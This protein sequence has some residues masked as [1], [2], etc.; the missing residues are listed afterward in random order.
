MKKL[1]SGLL[2]IAML[3]TL[4]A[5]GE[6]PSGSDQK[7]PQS[8]AP[9]DNFNYPTINQKLT[10]DA[11]NAFPIKSENMTEDEMRDLCVNFFRFTKTALWTPNQNWNFVRSNSGQTDDFPPVD[12]N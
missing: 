4:C 9:V 10:W 2:L 1:I 12:L 3:L 7:A 5:C 11:I 6:K 8:T